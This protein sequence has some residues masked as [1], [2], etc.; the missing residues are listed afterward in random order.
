MAFIE[1]NKTI[2]LIG[3]CPTLIFQ[4]LMYFTFIESQFNLWQEPMSENT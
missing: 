3:E 2:F 1:V 4:H